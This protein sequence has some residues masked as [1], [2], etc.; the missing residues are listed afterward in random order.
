MNRSVVNVEVLVVVVDVVI[1]MALVPKAATH[2][3]AWTHA[4][5]PSELGTVQTAL[6]TIVH[7]RVIICIFA[8]AMC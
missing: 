5:I 6:D 3:K 8:C 1:I 7:W 4:Q 2:P